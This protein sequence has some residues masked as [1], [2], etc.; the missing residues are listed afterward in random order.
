MD[1]WTIQLAQPADLDGVLDL[2]NRQF[3]E[4][5][6]SVSAAQLRTGVLSMLD[7]PSLGFFLIARQQGTITGLAC[8]SFCWTLEHGGKSAWL[9]ELYVRV[10]NRG[11]GIGHALLEAALRWAEEQ[12]CAAVDLEVDIEHR[13]AENLYRRAGFKPLP[14]SR[15]VKMLAGPPSWE[16]GNR[17][18]GI[19]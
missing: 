2:L 16:G 7:T 11:R 15:W 17:G 8:V 5:A 18:D 12:G 10:E 9:D 14:R 6:I 13:R 3:Q 19:N 4:H 1:E